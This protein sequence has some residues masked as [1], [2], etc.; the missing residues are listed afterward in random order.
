MFS[1]PMVA[2][3]RIEGK[4]VSGIIT[5]GGK[6]VGRLTGMLRRAEQAVQAVQAEQAGP[7]K[8]KAKKGA[9]RLSKHA[10]LLTMSMESRSRRLARTKL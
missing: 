6:T 2:K 1:S 5:C 9:C 4:S 7:M 3:D 8:V 10:A